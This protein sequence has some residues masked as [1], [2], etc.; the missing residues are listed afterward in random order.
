MKKK[1]LIVDDEQD[2]CDI[3]QFNLQQ[4]GY[5]VV[6]VNSAEQALSILGHTSVALVIL[7]VMMDGMDGFQMAS[8]MKH[9]PVL[10]GIP[11]IFTT[12]LDSEENIVKGLNIGADDYVTK[13]ISMRQLKA[14]VSAVLRRA[15]RA[16]ATTQLVRVGSLCLNPDTMLVTLDN[17]PLNLTKLEYKLLHNFLA[18]P[19]VLFTREQLI[20]R[21]WPDDTIV[22]D[23]SVNV[24]ITRLRKKMGEYGNQLKS[25]IGYG[26]VFEE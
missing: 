2:L 4:E 16:A 11:I 21:C 6:A 25:R 10:A 5:D 12:A 8:V 9:T 20:E 19:G 18:N 13:P 17:E 15:D 1:I 24:T 14:R 22:L 7:D 23:K 3:L 26:Y